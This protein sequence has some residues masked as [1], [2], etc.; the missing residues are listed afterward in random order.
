MKNTE[1]KRNISLLTE[2]RRKQLL[3]HL[4]RDGRVIAADLSQVFG[5]SDDTIRRD[6]DALAE[7]GQLQR[8]HGGAIRRPAVNH[9]YQTRQSESSAAKEGIARLAATLIQPGDVAIFDGGTTSLAIAQHLPERLAATVIT[10][11]PHVAVALANHNNIEVI[12]IGGRMYRYAMVAVGAETVAALQR[13]H[14]DICIVGV[15]AI[16][17]EVGLSVI[18]YEE[19]LTKQAMITAATRVVA[20]VTIEKLSTIAPFAVAP[21]TSITHLVTEAAVTVEMLAP[22]QFARLTIMQAEAE[23]EK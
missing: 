18:D 2:E 6:L 9:N 15:L 12:L 1:H 11:S 3:L 16:H 19:S 21:L 17:H 13:I 20:P 23:N 14:A 7:Q 5:V 10:T 8:V 4:Q 22:Y